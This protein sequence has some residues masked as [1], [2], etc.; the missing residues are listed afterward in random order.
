MVS[1]HKQEH[2]FE[3]E[4]LTESFT[5]TETIQLVSKSDLVRIDVTKPKEEQK[6]FIS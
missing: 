5:W 4:S 1:K 3:A 2:H 6:T